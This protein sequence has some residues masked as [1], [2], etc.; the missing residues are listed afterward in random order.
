MTQSVAKDKILIVDDIPANMWVLLEVLSDAGYDVLLA[1]SGEQALR[2]A[3]YA[4]PALILLD[5][6]MPN[7]DG[8]EVCRILKANPEL[9]KI[10]IIFMTALSDTINK[11]KGFELGAADYVTKP[12]QYKE[13]LAR[14]SAHL[15]VHKLQAE[16]V[17]R[18]AEL[19]TFSRMVAHDLKS[20][21][22]AVINLTDILAD[23]C[24]HDAEI[25]RQKALSRLRWVSKAGQQ[26]MGIVDALLLMAGVSQNKAVNIDVVNMNQI[27]EEVIQQR[28]LYMIKEYQAEV[29]QPPTLPTALGYAPWI[30]EIWANYISNAIKYGGKPPR[31]ELGATPLEDG[32]VQFWIKDNGRGLSEEEQ[33]KLFKPFTRLHNG[34]G[35]G[36]GLSIVQQIT[37]KLY[38]T[39]GVESE[40]GQGSRFYFTLP[41]LNKTI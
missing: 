28:L 19:E 16:L 13:V 23:E 26:M 7:M 39:V 24:E 4:K 40:L 38:G 8:F 29:I 30:H 3:E 10:P 31:L 6:M 18:N 5:V 9:C 12:I 32:M 41:S 27:V 2:V 21:L 15:E 34:D 37:D 33:G 35:H 25:D 1:Q 17:K 11:L 20:P 22:N 36:L 14:V